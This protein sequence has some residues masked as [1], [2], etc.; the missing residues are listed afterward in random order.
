MLIRPLPLALTILG[1]ALAIIGIP[2]S[3][4]LMSFGCLLATI[5]FTVLVM[6]QHET[7]GTHHV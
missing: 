4:E 3:D 2:T 5:S 6:T 1:I 7:K